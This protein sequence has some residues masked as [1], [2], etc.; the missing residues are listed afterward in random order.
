MA[1]GAA[2]PE[3]TQVIL[4]GASE[5]PHEPGLS[6]PRFRASAEAVRAYFQD[7]AGFALPGANLL[8][9]FD[10]DD[11]PSRLGQRVREFLHAGAGRC[12]DVIV[13]YIGHGSFDDKE[14]LLSLHDSRRDAP[15]T[16]YRFKHLHQ[17]VKGEARHARKF[18]VLDCCF[19]AAAV[20]ELMS[21]DAAAQLVIQEVRE[22][23][24]DDEPEKG[25]ALLCASSQTEAARAPGDQTYTMFTGSLLEALRGDTTRP[26]RLTLNQARDRAY[27]LMRERFRDQAVRPQVHSPDQSQGD[28]ASAIELLPLRRA[29]SAASRPGAARRNIADALADEAALGAAALRCVVV[30]PERPPGAGAVPLVQHVRRAIESHG[31]Q[32]LAAAES[33]GPLQL[34]EFG[35]ARAFA[36]EASLVRAVQVLCRAEVVVFDL[37][38]FEPG[39]VF[40]LGVR[41]VARRGVTVCSVGGDHCVGD[42]LDIPFNLQLLNLSA[43]SPQQ[44]RMG[45][46]MRPPDLIARKLETGFRDMANLP[47]YLDLPAFDS[48]R[49][50]G[51]ESSAYKGI[52][53][54]EQV[55]V[56][57]PF[58]LEYRDRNWTNVI[59]AELP[60]KLSRRLRDSGGP[61]DAQP[62][63]ARL[64]DLDTPRLVAQTLFESIRRTDMCL[65][66]WSGLRPNVMFEAGVRLATNRLGAVHIIEE[67]EGSG[68]VLP[69]DPPSHA[70]AMM[71]FFEPL[72]YTCEAG[73]DEPFERMIDR[74]EASLEQDRAGLT[75]FVYRAVGT[76]LDGDTSAQ[77]APIEDELVH[78]ANLL[79]SDDQ[80]STG[81]SPIL[82]H[83]VGKQ[84]VE[85]SRRAAQERRLAA[86]LYMNWRYGGAEI[87]ADPRRALQFDLLSVQVRRWAR[88]SG[89]T[90]LVDL[91]GASAV[92]AAADPGTNLASLAARVKARKEEAKDCRDAQDLPGAVTVL[93]ADGGHAAQLAL[94]RHAVRR[95]RLGHR[96]REGARLAPGRLPGHA[97][98]QPSPARTARPGAAGL[99]RRGP[100]RGGRP[101]RG[102]ELLQPRQ[103]HRAAAGDEAQHGLRPA[104]RSAP[105]R[106]RHRAAGA[107]RAPQRPLGLGRPRPVPA[108]AGRARRGAHQLRPHAPPGRRRHAQVGAAGAG[109]LARRAAGQRPGDRRRAGRRH[110]R[111]VR[112]RVRAAACRSRSPARRH[113]GPAAPGARC[114]PGRRLQRR[115]TGTAAEPARAPWPAR[116]AAS[117][118][119][120]ARRRSPGG[121]PLARRAPG[122]SAGAAGASAREPRRQA[123]AAARR[124]RP[125]HDARSPLRPAA[126]SAAAAHGARGRQTRTAGRRRPRPA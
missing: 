125:R 102:A 66:D 105:R 60:G 57:C 83:D 21:D 77:P 36:S 106:R 88:Q 47:H 62:R 94:A 42:H 56:L 85:R 73:A 74:F 109:A 24:K 114:R 19:A 14:Y 107:R 76:T 84:L 27:A 124:C 59:A 65:I 39:V 112:L 118:R 51:L 58:S 34:A 8:D 72:R 71:G 28:I 92:R 103:R 90:D 108:A 100:L 50:L 6:N 97:G 95:R 13:Y 93:R 61:A 99:R 80:E 98:R 37:T 91:V 68:P 31:A 120:I 48:V 46:G 54:A 18:F 29:D 123:I 17:A 20:R 22:G 30:S 5:Y 113:G 53:H 44:S 35:V 121:A 81:I 11:A 79:F 116:S 1:T 110:R 32:I 4:L 87:A 2:S 89:R 45:E 16:R 7:P 115:P 43:H 55:L 75:G 49:Q 70:Q 23:A 33:A 82:F 52:G 126:A 41:A 25:T 117:T 78:G 10:S 15:D 86:W 122:S 63:L 67:R 12:K 3:A 9:L 96:G 26:R 104:G 64:L 101:P 119:C 69:A 38:G 40:L 111:A